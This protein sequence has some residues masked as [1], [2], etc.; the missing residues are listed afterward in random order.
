MS[1]IC[2]SKQAFKALY[3]HYYK[4]C[5]LHAS[6]TMEVDFGM[7]LGRTEGSQL[8]LDRFDA[9]VRTPAGVLPSVLEGDIAIKVHSN[10]NGDNSSAFALEKLLKVLCVTRN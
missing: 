10:L 9:L 1:E 6:G 3:M 8:V 2:V 4:Q 5:L 7:L